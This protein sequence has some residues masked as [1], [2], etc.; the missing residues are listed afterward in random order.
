MSWA[1]IRSWSLVQPSGSGMSIQGSSVS[2][3][4]RSS[5]SISAIQ[6]EPKIDTLLVWNN[7]EVV[8]E[9]YAYMNEFFTVNN[10]ERSNS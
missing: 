7:K 10:I 1:W 4:Q 2:A 3:L 9:K 5:P 8:Y 6:E